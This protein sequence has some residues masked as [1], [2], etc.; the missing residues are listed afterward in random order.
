MVFGFQ[1]ID[2]AV[3]EDTLID[4]YFDYIWTRMLEV[5][6][7]Q[8][9]EAPTD[10]G[11]TTN[12]FPII[13]IAP[14]IQLRGVYGY[15]AFGTWG[16]VGAELYPHQSNA[17]DHVVWQSCEFINWK[18]QHFKAPRGCNA[19]RIWLRTANRAVAHYYTYRGVPDAP[20]GIVRDANGN[21]I[22]PPP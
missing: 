17:G 14:R 21:Q 9:L 15:V 5:H 20:T 3:N 2:W 6:D 4:E 11:Q 8:W 12:L 7:K 16:T 1:I 13:D 10:T 22:W 18:E 19:L